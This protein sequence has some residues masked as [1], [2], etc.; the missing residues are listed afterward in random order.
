MHKREKGEK[1]DLISRETVLSYIN[2]HQEEFHQEHPAQL[3]L[4]EI[5]R[6]VKGM[7]NA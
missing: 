6:F 7:S 5:E 2:T 3:A 4:A 1:S